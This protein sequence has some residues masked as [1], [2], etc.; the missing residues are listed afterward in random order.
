MAKFAY[1]L[2]FVNPY[3]SKYASVKASDTLIT[4]DS[5]RAGKGNVFI[6]FLQFLCLHHS[7][8]LHII[9]V[10]TQEREVSIAFLL[11]TAL[12]D[13][14]VALCLR[15]CC[16]PWFRLLAWRSR[17]K[18]GRWSLRKGL[19][20]WRHAPHIALTEEAEVGSPP[21]KCLIIITLDFAGL[22]CL[23]LLLLLYCKGNK[24]SLIVQENIEK[25]VRS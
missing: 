20:E 2:L 13:A 4:I 5:P 17:R 10:S 7:A 14:K 18:K 3:T 21:C 1:S 6:P 22:I 23:R 9:S 24:N 19:Q 8:L 12:H 11:I 16:K 25:K 15:L